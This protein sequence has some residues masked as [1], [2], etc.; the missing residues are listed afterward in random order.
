MDLLGMTA[1]DD[2]DAIQDSYR[3]VVVRA[4]EKEK[5]VIKSALT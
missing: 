1:P 2:R 3:I 4:V 5:H